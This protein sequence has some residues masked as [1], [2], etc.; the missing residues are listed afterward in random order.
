MGVRA[1]M[2]APRSRLIAMVVA[3]SLLPVALGLAIGLAGAYAAGPAV[4]GLLFGVGGRDPITL[5]GT[6]LVLIAVAAL[7]S[8]LP[9][10]RAAR[11][12]PV[13]ALRA[14]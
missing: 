13:D 7:A 9:A 12:D 3:E 14:R 11:T 5:G 10:W 8:W 1:A 4:S 2:G 6:A